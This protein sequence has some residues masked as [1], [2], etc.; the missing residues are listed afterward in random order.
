VN[1]NN[2]PSHSLLFK[3][4]PFIVL[5]IIKYPLLDNVSIPLYSFTMHPLDGS[6][7]KL[8]R[9]KE[10]FKAVD[11]AI[12]GLKK[13]KVYRLVGGV[14]GQGKTRQYL[15]RFHQSEPLPADL[16]LIIG[17]GCSNLRSA[18]DHLIW[19]LHVLQAP[20]FRRNVKFP[21]W[22][23]ESLF[24][25]NA[26]RDI[27]DL[28]DRQRT[29]IESLQPYRTRQYGLSLLRDANDTDKHRLMQ[30]VSLRGQFQCID[31]RFDQSKARLRVPL[32]IRPTVRMIPRGAEIKDGAI[33]AWISLNR[34][35][36]GTDMYVH[37]ILDIDYAFTGGKVTKLALITPSL[38]LMVSEVSRTISSLESE[39]ASFGVSTFK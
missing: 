28:T 13:R 19:Q 25:K 10:H 6:F 21:I 5:L 39:F 2:I 9:A 26:P 31:I 12:Q 11:D 4:K 38:I 23:K 33:V 30:I 24:D 32:T 35:S 8:R 17:D 27:R 3:L 16:P 1:V 34:V 15:V 22:D 29:T 7:L 14:V 20:S 36:Q 37:D 18:L